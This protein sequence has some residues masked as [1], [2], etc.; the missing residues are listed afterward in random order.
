MCERVI[1]AAK[2]LGL[3]QSITSSVALD[4]Y[5]SI[6]SIEADDEKF[7]YNIATLKKDINRLLELGADEARI[8][9]KVKAINSDF[10]KSKTV[11][12]ERTGIQLNERIKRGIIYE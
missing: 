1:K 4:K 5:C 6:P 7:C 2:E 3:K 11:K 9:K 12:V 8:C 10:C